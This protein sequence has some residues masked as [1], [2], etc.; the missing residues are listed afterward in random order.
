[1]PPSVIIN[2]A[3]ADQKNN[4]GD[5]STR[6]FL[7]AVGS[8]AFLALVGDY[9]TGPKPIEAGQGGWCRRGARAGSIGSSGDKEQESV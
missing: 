5:K 1:M 2:L 7:M 3:D 9:A 8:W 6:T 4:S